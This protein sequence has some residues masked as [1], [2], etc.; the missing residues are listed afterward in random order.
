MLEGK[1]R[2]R[3][4]AILNP[5]A[6]GLARVGITATL[7]TFVGLVIAGLAAWAIA[8]DR[9]GW[10]VVAL[11][12]AGVG[13]LC[14]GA[15]ARVTGSAGP[16]G[17]FTDSVVDRA[18]DALLFGGCAWFY[19][20]REPRLAVLALAVGA[21]SMLISYERAKAESLGLSGKGGVIERAE[22]LLILGTALLFN[23][24]TAGLWILLGLSL[25]TVVYRFVRVV[26]QT[27]T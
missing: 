2:S 9:W 5:V 7:L 24:L 4:D 25:L 3:T 19:S 1:L 26:S 21:T 23:V 10:A 11:V 12:I 15:V 22:R 14:D 20:E 8:V 16:R 27:K 17:A 6:R 18:S 13:D